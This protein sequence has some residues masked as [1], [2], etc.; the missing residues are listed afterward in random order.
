M[1][2]GAQ[3]SFENFLKILLECE[4]TIFI[5]FFSKMFLTALSLMWFSI[6][7]SQCQPASKNKV[8]KTKLSPRRYYTPEEMLKNWF[9]ERIRILNQN[10]D[11]EE[12]MTIL[13]YRLSPEGGHFCKIMSLI[14]L[15]CPDLPWKDLSFWVSSKIS[16]EK[17]VSC[18][19]FRN[20]R[21]VPLDSNTCS[22]LGRHK[23]RLEVGSS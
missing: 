7:V 9:R 2:A 15:V 13:Q 12:V 11:M 6:S 16:E 17:Q 14:F 20:R 5:L 23:D 19:L 10:L 4:V 1:A 8:N 3:S 18:I 22:M 21:E